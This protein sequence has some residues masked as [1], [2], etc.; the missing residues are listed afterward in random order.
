MS[1]YRLAPDYA[2]GDFPIVP[3]NC[4][5]YNFLAM[6]D[7]ERFSI[8]D[9]IKHFTHYLMMN[10]TSISAYFINI[11]DLIRLITTY[12]NDVYRIPLNDKD[13]F[14]K[15]RATFLDSYTYKPSLYEATSIRKASNDK[16]TLTIDCNANKTLSPNKVP[17]KDSE[18]ISS[19][20]LTYNENSN[21]LESHSNPEILYNRA[22]YELN[23][24]NNEIKVS[25]DVDKSVSEE[26]LFID[27]I[28]DKVAEVTIQQ[29]AT[30]NES[31][32]EDNHICQNCIIKKEKKEIQTKKLNY[33]NCMMNNCFYS[34]ERYI[35]NKDFS[36]VITIFDMES[37]TSFMSDMI[38][39]YF[40]GLELAN[41][42]NKQGILIY[43]SYNWRYYF[44][45]IELAGIEP[46][47]FHF[48][49]TGKT[50]SSFHSFEVIGYLNKFGTCNVKVHDFQAMYCLVN[51]T[52]NIPLFQILN[53]TTLLFNKNNQDFY[54]IAMRNY[55]DIYEQLYS[56]VQENELVL[57]AYNRILRLY[58]VLAKSYDLSDI[59]E[60]NT[61]GIK[62]NYYNDF[63]FD[64]NWS[65]RIKKEGIAYRIVL[66]NG[67]I[68]T[69]IDSDTLVMDICLLFKNMPHSHRLRSRILSISNVELIVFYE[70]S[71]IEGRRFYD[72]LVNGIRIAYSR[73]YSN[74][75]M[76]NSY[77]IR[78][79][80]KT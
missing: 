68:S 42:N 71:E 14:Q 79:A 34:P 70:G 9:L 19:E 78:F 24:D 38:H 66:P 48:S 39:S 20:P 64:F 73:R 55:K 8:E 15:S 75:L 23:A 59:C 57:L 43:C 67:C 54:Q 13:D 76:T 32:K 56:Q 80:S 11:E 4:Y 16:E 3:L 47:N 62:L 17:E 33:D 45:D 51:N 61:P 25:K 35:I 28:N 26:E 77:S 18:I 46:L 37:S 41:M 53:D 12:I 40:I 58:S 63:S 5:L 2:I 50:F 22:A 31:N 30:Y 36:S 69:Q 65:Q 49:D 44:Y 27:M 6:N 7:K 74:V 21:P 60:T 52:K 72:H 10:D 29:I 1:L